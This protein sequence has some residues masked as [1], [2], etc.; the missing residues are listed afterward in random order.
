MRIRLATLADVET[1]AELRIEMFRDMGRAY[2]G[3]LEELDAV[4]RPWIAESIARGSVTGL[5]AEEDDRPVGGMQ[6]AWLDVP[7]SRVDRTGRTAYLYGLRV[8]PEYRRRGIAVSLLER[9]I[10]I[11]RERG[12][13]II[14]LQA[15]EEGRAV[16]AKL[17]F[18]PTTEM[19][20]VL[21]GPSGG[22]STC[23]IAQP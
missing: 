20:L 5:I 18:E 2:E 6:I 11:A 13:G 23:D 12:A 7:P 15:S 8:L 17:G 9:A 1:L 10:E 19:A 21:E 22:S 3:H 14:T 4:Q 16:Y